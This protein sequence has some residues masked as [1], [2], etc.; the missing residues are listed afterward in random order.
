MGGFGKMVAFEGVAAL[1]LFAFGRLAPALKAEA[2]AS[3]KATIAEAS[4]ELAEQLE[5]AEQLEA[6]TI[7]QLMGSNG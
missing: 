5:Q 3:V 4:P 1:A 7:G 6:Q 2:T